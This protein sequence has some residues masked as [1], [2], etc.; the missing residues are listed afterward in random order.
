MSKTGRTIGWRGIVI[1]LICGWVASAGSAQQIDWNSGDYNRPNIPEKLTGKG[2]LHIKPGSRISFTH[3]LKDGGNFQW[4]LNYYLSVYR[5]TNQAYGG[6]MTANIN[7]RGSVRCYNYG[8]KNAAGDEVEI[9]DRYSHKRYGESYRKGLKVFRRV[10][11]YKDR[12]LARWLEILHNPTNKAVTVNV[13]IYSN[14]Y[15]SLEALATPDGDSS[16]KKDEKGFISTQ[17]HRDSAPSIMHVIGDSRGQSQTSVK[18]SGNSS[19][20]NVE[21]TVTIPANDYRLICTFQ[22]QGNDRAKLLKR[23]RSFRAWKHLRDLNPEI[24]RKIVNFGRISGYADIY[25]LRS[26]STD[27]IFLANG[28]PIFGDIEPGEFLLT[29][30]FG[31]I[32]LPSEDVIGMAVMTDANDTPDPN[33]VMKVLL[34]GGNLLHGT[35][36]GQKV[37]I[38][39]GTAT[40]EVPVTHMAQWSYRISKTRPEFVEHKPPRMVLRSGIRL[41][42]EPKTMTLPI[43]WQLGKI[44]VRIA[45]VHEVAFD[46]NDANQVTVS[47]LSG[48]T[49]AGRLET[50][51]LRPALAFDGNGAVP[52][53]R[54]SKIVHTNEQPERAANTTLTL[55]K[56]L[57]AVVGNQKQTVLSG[58]LGNDQIELDIDGASRTF[59]VAVIKDLKFRASPN[60]P[61]S[62][63]TWNDG[64]K[65][66][67]L[68]TRTIVIRMGKH[69]RIEVD[70]NECDHLKRARMTAPADMEQDAVKWIAQLGHPTRQ[71]RQEATAKLKAMNKV[72][73]PLLRRSFH[74][75]R[76]PEVRARIEAVLE[77]F[78]ESIQPRKADTPPSIAL[79]KNPNFQS[80]HEYR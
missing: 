34:R 66:G 67:L 18:H 71:K 25:L 22:S 21:H 8:W 26:D 65:K 78:K 28:D 63:T 19:N 35:L 49:L 70:A 23:L 72:I 45:D 1:T 6:A 9:F 27:R 57:D 80:V 11:V 53:S 40:L 31:R 2:G 68:R 51:R 37:G 75:S 33:G 13:K 77:H 42:V 39:M 61:V 69:S 46:P 20:L 52:V 17:Q 60:D 48:S 3:T 74:S 55:R 50:D 56:T 14:F 41:P 5:G 30:G 43:R 10:K 64:V 32:R 62:L 47:F 54:I 36:D 12:P 15:N 29:T 79:P 58:T 24:R 7:N 44:D 59:D 38:S 73:V 76:D 4:D 16:W